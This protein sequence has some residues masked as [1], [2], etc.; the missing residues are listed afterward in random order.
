MQPR[1]IFLII[2]IAVFAAAV[3]WFARPVVHSG[4]G[5]SGGRRI[6][7]YQSPMHPWIKS[8]EPGNCTI[9]G[10]ALV[11]VYEG[12]KPAESDP[13]LISLSQNSIN[14]IHVQAEPARRQPLTRVLRVAGIIDEDISRHRV[15]SAYV[16]GRIDKL[17][18]NYIGAEV[19]EGQPLA[20]LYSPTLLND[21]R[22]YLAL[23]RR[24]G[25]GG[26][27]D[28]LLA[29]AR[30]RLSQHGLTEAQ[31]AA[32]PGKSEDDIH[33]EIVAPMT[34]QIVARSVYEGQYVK[35]GDPLFEIADFST[36][37]GQFDVYERDLAWLREG[38]RAEITAD[39][40]PDR[41]IEGRVTF[42]NQNID[43]AT[44]TAKVR[45]E[46]PNPLVAG[47]NG[48][49]HALFHKTYADA[50]IRSE[51]PETLTV[52]RSA[53]LSPDADAFVYV[54]KGGGAYEQRAVK[55]GRSGEG[56]WEILD[57]LQE[58]ERVVTT[59]NLL[60]DAQAQIMRGPTEPPASEK[61][62]ELTQEQTRLAT[63]FVA[64][65]DAIAGAL[66]ADKL[67]PFNKLTADTHVLVPALVRAF[68]NAPEWEPLVLPLEK[69]EHL[70]A[71][72]DIGAAR[73]QFLGFG[74]ASVAFVKELRKR[75]VT[76]ALIYEC[77]M[78]VTPPPGGSATGTWLQIKG[79]IRNPFLGLAM[80]DC[81]SEVQP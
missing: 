32:L 12:K 18:V 42:I 64:L 15:L 17:E 57:G 78:A 7:F 11:P 23:L 34:G 50:A 58:G 10:M 16:D 9:C 45:V 70:Q 38:Q 3:G 60:I 66:A 25:L 28:A 35:E 1:T 69:A 49:R 27:G 6:A 75:K 21:R 24:P 76:Q 43:E 74:N 56:V 81:G 80:P 14:V 51:T 33:T 41:V 19:T 54:D 77:P 46:I 59:G 8:P 67:E 53:V 20:T 47:T 2:I 5:D 36:M 39:S 62:G 13:K 44:R 61:A 37:W 40:S 52:P 71:A 22:E 29:A 73:K 79:P 68:R 48:S 55:P 65:A 4:A 30:R 31:I 26:A 63:E 72:P